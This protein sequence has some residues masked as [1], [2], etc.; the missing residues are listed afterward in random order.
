MGGHWQSSPRGAP[1]QLEFSGCSHS[2]RKSR[3]SRNPA[4]QPRSLISSSVAAFGEEFLGNYGKRA[5]DELMFPSPV[6]F[7]LKKK[8]VQMICALPKANFKRYSLSIKCHQACVHLTQG[9]TKQLRSSSDLQTK[10]PEP[11]PQRYW[12]FLN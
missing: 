6:C 12:V 9:D 3:C 4:V 7:F 11:N 10:K 2:Q 1:V 5:H 8:N